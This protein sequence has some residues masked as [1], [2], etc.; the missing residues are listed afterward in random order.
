M[1]VLPPLIE[2]DHLLD[3]HLLHNLVWKHSLIDQ[4]LHMSE[5]LGFFLSINLVFIIFRLFWSVLI[6]FY[7]DLDADPD[8]CIFKDRLTYREAE[9]YCY[10]SD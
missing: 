1:S 8:D 7:K 4:L 3:D 2:A 10:N 6:I 5:I 9:D